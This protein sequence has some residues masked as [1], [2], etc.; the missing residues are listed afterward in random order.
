MRVFISSS[1]KRLRESSS[2][3]AE[4]FPAC[5]F[6]IGPFRTAIAIKAFASSRSLKPPGKAL[7]S[8]LSAWDS[9][10][11]DNALNCSLRSR[12]IR[13]MS[14]TW[15]VILFDVGCFFGMTLQRF[16]RYP[17]SF[18]VYHIAGN[19]ARRCDGKGALKYA[20]TP[21]QQLLLTCGR[22]NSNPETV[23]SYLEESVDGTFDV[24]VSSLCMPNAERVEFCCAV[25]SEYS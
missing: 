19:L 16:L 6:S 8:R 10:S 20:P 17:P 24:V 3:R 2:R 15:D 1:V 22:P 25:L 4:C 14:G 7:S 9:S 21:E 18:T 11:V 23:P 12:T 13:S 5:K